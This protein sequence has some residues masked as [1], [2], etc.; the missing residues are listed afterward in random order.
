M[1]LNVLTKMSSP[2]NRVPE[3]QK[4]SYVI[5]TELF[6]SY[7]NTQFI[8]VCWMITADFKMKVNI[9]W[10]IIINIPKIKRIKKTIFHEKTM[11]DAITT[12]VLL[13]LILRTC[14]SHR[15]RPDSLCWASVTQAYVKK[16]STKLSNDRS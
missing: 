5:N 13:P 4:P 1:V 11:W 10:N 8:N 7:N 6:A 15:M 14:Q 3:E 2:V 12:L 9:P 16:D